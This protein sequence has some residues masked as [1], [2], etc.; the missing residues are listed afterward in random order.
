MLYG[1]SPFIGKTGLDFNLKPVMTLSSAIMAIQDIGQGEKVGYRGAWVCPQA[2]RIGIVAVGYGDGYP[3]HARTGT[4]VLVNN[5][6]VPLV[7]CVSM[8]MIMVDLRTQPD[9]KIGDPVTLWGQ[10]L[11]I[12]EIA[13]CAETI[14]YE[15]TCK[16][17][18]RLP[19][20]Y[21]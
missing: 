21:K 6:R 14:P 11:P 10:G 13:V 4:P 19:R 2:M 1:I 18:G 17:T 8:D 5:N 20:F 3:W 16:V 15:L 9:A 7:G 12:E